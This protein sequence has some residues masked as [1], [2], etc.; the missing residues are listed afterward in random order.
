MTPPAPLSPAEAKTRLLEAARAVDPARRIG[1]SL[2]ARPRGFL[3]AALAGGFALSALSSVSLRRWLRAAEGGLP[4]L[5]SF[6]SGLLSGA[7]AGNAGERKTE[8]DGNKN[9]DGKQGTEGGP[10]REAGR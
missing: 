3:L 9:D 5:S 4:L 8:G 6:L 10:G 1:E 7:A 2:R